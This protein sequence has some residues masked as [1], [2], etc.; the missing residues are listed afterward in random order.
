MPTIEETINTLKDMGFPEVISK[1]WCLKFY[2][3]YIHSVIQERAKKALNK[4][5]WAGVE[6]A[7]E[8]LLS[9]PE[10]EVIYFLNCD[11]LYLKIQKKRP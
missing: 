6:A 1:Y 11:N 8:W 7:M 3:S 4:T 10:D 9:H 2:K 5:G